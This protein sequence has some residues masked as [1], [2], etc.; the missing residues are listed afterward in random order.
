MK[1]GNLWSDAREILYPS[2]GKVIT[3]PEAQRKFTP[4]RKSASKGPHAAPY[5]PAYDACK[6]PRQEPVKKADLATA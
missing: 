1:R 6:P 2:F 5:R 3:A 4:R